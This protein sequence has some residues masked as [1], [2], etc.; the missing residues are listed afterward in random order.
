M[1]FTTF[2][3]SGFAVSLT[4]WL[5][6]GFPTGSHRL[7]LVSLR[8]VVT[9]F[10]TAFALGRT[11]CRVCGFVIR[12]GLVLASL[13]IAFGSVIAIGFG[14]YRPSFFWQDF[15]L[16]F[17]IA[18]VQSRFSL[19]TFFVLFADVPLADQVHPLPIPGKTRRRPHH[20]PQRLKQ[21]RIPVIKGGVG[22]FEGVRGAVP[23][24]LE[25]GP[26]DAAVLGGEEEF[27]GLAVKPLREGRRHLPPTDGVDVG[28]LG[29]VE[30]LPGIVKPRHD[31]RV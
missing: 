9:S 16:I 26:V 14:I 10:I 4:Y 31:V 6:R 1:S 22:V 15:L 12:A 8:A 24:N 13:S 25:E 17:P 7:F 23:A 19:L 3:N 27:P 28:I 29:K 5:R 11:F 21:G 18:N 20:F 2:R 30:D